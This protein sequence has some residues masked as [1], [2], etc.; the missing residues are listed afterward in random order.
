MVQWWYLW[1]RRE[2]DPHHKFVLVDKSGR[3]SDDMCIELAHKLY[4]EN[5]RRLTVV[6]QPANETPSHGTMQYERDHRDIK[7]AIV[8]AAHENP[9]MGVAFPKDVIWLK[10]GYADDGVPLPADE[11]NW[12]RCGK[13]MPKM[14]KWLMTYSDGSAELYAIGQ[15]TN[16]RRVHWVDK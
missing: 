8:C 12:C 10:V 14:A 9:E 11:M 16:C 6:A 15:C 13:T 4:G 5:P 7:W 3:M 1:I 2:D